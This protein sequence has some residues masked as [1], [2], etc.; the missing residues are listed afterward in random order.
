MENLFGGSSQRKCD[1][2]ARCVNAWLQNVVIGCSRAE[3]IRDIF[4]VGVLGYHTDQQ[5]NAIIESALMG[6]LAGKAL[7]SI[8]EIGNNPVR[9]DT[10]VGVVYDEETGEWI[11]MPQQVPVWV[12]PKAEGGTPTCTVLHHAFEV[13][14]GWINAHPDSFPPIVINVTDGESQ[15]GDPIP[16][17]DAL[18]DLATRD[19]NVLLFNCYL[20]PTS[21]S[22]MFPASDETL[23]DDLARVL[24]EMSSIL[25]DTMCSLAQGLECELQPN[26]RGMALSADPTTLLRFLDIGTRVTR[27]RG[28]P[29]ISLTSKP[30][31]E[32]Q[33][34]AEKAI[35]RELGP[36]KAPAVES[37][38]EAYWDEN[39][40]FTVFRPKA[41][42]PQVWCDL[43]ASAHLEKKRPD[44]STDES[45]PIEKARSKARS[46]L[47]D[48][49]PEKI[50]ESTHD[51]GQAIPQG[52]Q[53]TFVPQMDNV[54]FNPPQQSFFWEEDEHTVTF[55][56][57]AIAAL[58]GKV[59]RGRMAVFL[60]VI[61]VADIPLRFEVSHAAAE[62]RKTPEQEAVTARPYRKIFASYSHRDLV[63]VEQF[64]RY[65]EAIGD[66][67]LRDWKNLR[68]GDR[69][70][71]KLLQLIDGADVFQLFW[72]RNS[73]TSPFVRQEWEHALSLNRPSFVRPVYWEDPLPEAPPHL[74]PESLRRIHFQRLRVGS[75]SHSAPPTNATYHS[76]AIIS[77]QKH[78]KESLVGCPQRKDVRRRSNVFICY[79]HEDSEASTGRICDRLR[80]CFGVENV[81]IDIYNMRL[82]DFPRQ[83]DEAVSQCDVLLAIIGAQ[84]LSARDKNGQRRLDSPED[85]VRMEIER[86]LASNTLVVPVLVDGAQIPA[87]DALPSTLRALVDCEAVEVQSGRQF[88][89]DIRRLIESLQQHFGIMPEPRKSV[90]GPISNWALR[91]TVLVVAFLL[92]AGGSLEVARWQRPRD[93]AIVPLSP[94]RKQIVVAWHDLEA[95]SVRV[96][97]D[98][99]GLPDPISSDHLYLAT[100]AADRRR[101]W[102]ITQIS[103]HAGDHEFGLSEGQKYVAIVCPT[104]GPMRD[105]MASDDVKVIAET[106]LPK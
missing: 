52:G 63:I 56:L 85:F 64:E 51:S 90:K 8:C 97:W 84:W 2:L 65:A 95:R 99:S 20:S 27:D 75:G 103:V 58:E 37:K 47:K 22:F 34:V 62:I 28:T 80:L 15:D 66:D 41:I 26:A 14:E 88:D 10:V 87:A 100:T 35:D 38:N 29:G 31:I 21:D 32:A 18:K 92:V 45:A 57:R 46:V 101:Y 91:A 5:G 105:D 93:P 71:D 42:P 94:A 70:N 43:V 48:L 61:L 104:K 23:P 36:P 106:E 55:R 78:A 96:T 16:Y 3:G 39:V 6:A 59:A 17:A 19:G 9:T 54:Q 25:P 74:P 12:D 73:M 77:P 60:G 4:D 102:P 13:I 49:S 30:D 68:P 7:V 76:A 98:I 24:F 40:Q 86:A 53:I 44:A 50:R 83:L 1:E 81:F 89:D 67:Y 69:W 11:E 33:S 72:S 82:G 79:R